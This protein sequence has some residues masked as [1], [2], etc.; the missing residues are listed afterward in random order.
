MDDAK[1]RLRSKH[2]A[3]GYLLD[4]ERDYDLD[5]WKARL[6]WLLRSALGELGDGPDQAP[7]PIDVRTSATVPKDEVWLVT[8]PGVGVRMKVGSPSG[9]D[10]K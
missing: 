9:S 10:D 3:I 2:N 7:P 1:K 6:R 5:S 8:G 4:H